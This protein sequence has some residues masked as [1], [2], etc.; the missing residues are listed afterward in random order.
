MVTRTVAIQR[1]N[2]GLGFRK[3]GNSLES[4]IVL[5]L[6]EAQRDLEKGKTLP[7][8][9][10]QEDVSVALASGASTAALP[11]GFLRES[12]ENTLHYFKSGSDKPHY[13]ARR[14]LKDA[15]E[16]L[17][18]SDDV[19]AGPPSVYV[20]R[21]STF[22][23]I[24]TADTD[25]TLYLDYYKAADSLA[26]DVENAWLANAPEW[27]IGEAGLRIAKDLRDKSAVIIFSDMRTSGRAAAF[28]EDIAGELAAGP[29]EMGANL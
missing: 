21:K 3:D 16:A 28:G 27:L 12:D 15:R 17:L 29:I 4:K 18:D 8:F 13:L 14:Y 2:R 20:V 9:L 5:T 24:I 6:Q 26:A 10:L 23:F 11:T 7:R 22:D 1:I 25:Y 19:A